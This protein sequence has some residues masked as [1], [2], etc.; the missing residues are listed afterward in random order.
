MKPTYDRVLEYAKRAVAAERLNP[1]HGR[2]AGYDRT[3]AMDDVLN[4]FNGSALNATGIMSTYGQTLR[5]ELSD[6]DMIEEAVREAESA[7]GPWHS[8][9]RGV[10]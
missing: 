1:A 4:H 3:S 5:L 10:Q 2:I 9:Q 8:W 6:V 7:G